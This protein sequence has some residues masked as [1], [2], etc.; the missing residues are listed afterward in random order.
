MSELLPTLQAA[1]LQEGLTKYLT[2]AFALADNDAQLSL[3]DF[4]ADPRDGIFKGPYVRIRLPFRPATDGWHNDLDWFEGFPPYGHQA[5]AFTR[6]S[7]A[8]LSD[9][10][11]RPLPTLVTTGT[12][13]GKTEAF[14]TPIIDHV[15]RAK[16]AGITGMKALILYPMNALAN[17][18]AKRLTEL[19]TTHD[20]LAGITAA[21]YTGQK[22]DKR[23]RVSAA[24]LITD[25][26]IMQDSAPDIVLTNYKMLDQLLLRNKDAPLWKQSAT[27]LQYIVLDEFHT[28]D[29]AQGTDV[30]M[31][32]RRLG[33][34]LKSYWTPATPGITPED[35][36]RPL[37]KITPIATSATLGDKGNPDVML[38]FAE[39]VF[40]EPFG[41][42]TVIT[43]TRL[44]LE[45][46][47]APGISFMA[48]RNL[49]PA[50]VDE[51]ELGTL[52]KAVEKLGQFAEARD[53]SR[54]VLRYLYPN[55]EDEAFDDNELLLAATQAH[56]FLRQLI[57]HTHE[58]AS[59]DDLAARVFTNTLGATETHEQRDTTRKL[60]LHNVIAML[61]HVRKVVGR[62]AASIDVHLW[63]RELSRIDR[64]ATA[65][66]QYQWS[67]DGVAIALPSGSGAEDA[68]RSYFP[69]VYCRHCGRSGWGVQLSPAGNNLDI[70]DTKI[71][72]NHLSREGRFRALMYAPREADPH[73]RDNTGSS[74]VEGL[75]WF[76]TKDRVLENSRPADDNPEFIDGYILPVLTQTGTEQEEESHNDDCPSCQQSDGIRFLGSAIATLLS[77]SLSNLFGSP[78]LDEGE[79][80]ALVFT[81]SVQDAAHRAGFIQSRSH[82]LSLRS[83]FHEA[84]GGRRINLEE[85]V[86]ETLQKAG[87]NK[88]RR[89]QLIA[90]DYADRDN[91]LDFWQAD[92]L[93]QTKAGTRTRVSHRLLFDALME[94][95]LSSRVGRT[96]E[97]TGSVVAEVDAGSS[98]KLVAI[99]R[100]I[101]DSIEAQPVIGYTPPTDAQ[102]A[103][104]VRG[105]LENL[106]HRG[107]IVHPWLVKYIRNDGARHWV[108]RGRPRADGMSA[109]PKGRQ[110]PA[111]ARIGGSHGVGGYTGE[112][113]N[114]A[115][116]QSWY[117][118]WA[119]KCLN[120]P[121]SDGAKFAKT[122]FGRLVDAGLLTVTNADSGAQIYG[123]SPQSILVSE[124]KLDDIRNGRHFL[125][126]SVCHS[127][128]PESIAV[129]DDLD[130]APCLYLRCPGT[131]VRQS[132]DDNYYR[133]L[134]SSS[135]MRRVVA[136][137][138]TGLLDDETRLRYENQ[139]KNSA[140][141][142]QAP[143][144]LVATP[145]LEMGIDIGDLSTV[146]LASLPR[147]VAS[148][149][150]RIGRAGRLTG[151]SLSLAFVRGRGEHLPKLGQPL[152]VINGEVRPPATYLNA[153]EILQ[154][155]FVAHLMDAFARDDTRQH[156]RKAT[157]AIGSALPDTFLG[158]IIAFAERD[159]TTHLATFLDAFTG[160]STAAV[161]SLTSWVTPFTDEGSSALAAHLYSASQRWAKTVSELEF[162]RVAIQASL[163]ELTAKALS[164][165]A[166]DD[167]KWAERS[168]KSNLRMIG[169]Q[170]ADLRGEFWIGVLEEYGILPNYT[171]LDDSVT[172]DFSLTWIDPDSGTFESSSHEYH[173]GSS[174]ALTELAPGATFYAEGLE[175]VVDAVDL[176]ANASAIRTL[177]FCP[178]CGF[179]RDLNQTGELIAVEV[180]PRCGSKAIADVKQ[181][182]EVV[183]LERVS[184]EV[185]RDEASINDSRDDRKRE[186]FST[187]VTADIDPEFVT[188][189]WF[190]DGYDFGVKYLRK[191]DVKWLNLGRATVANG[192]KRAIA[193]GEVP[194]PLFRVCGH[195][196]KLDSAA[197]T[198]RPEEH[199]AWCKY[200]K[201]EVESTRE[202]ALSHT[203]STQGA[204]I[205]LP[206]A[207]TIGDEFAGPSL[208]AAL[209]LGLRDQL[210]GSPDHIQI[211]TVIDPTT[212]EDGVNHEALLM[213]DTVPGGTGYLAEF[214]NP[215][216]VWDIIYRAWEVVKDCSCRN[217][218]RLACHKC[219]LPFAAPWQVDSV[220]RA[221]AERY[222]FQILSSG[223]S[224]ETNADSAPVFADWSISLVDTSVPNNESLL[225]QR[226]R[227]DLVARLKAVGA[228]VK[229]IPGPT[230]NRVVFTIPATHQTWTLNPQVQLPNCVPDFVLT[231]KV[232][233]VPKVAIFT[234]GWSFHA[235][236]EH[237]RTADDAAKR[238]TLR[239]AGYH[240]M[241]ITWEDLELGL[242]A[243]PLPGWFNAA[244]T[245]AV[246]AQ[247]A[248]TPRVLKLI[249]L[250]PMSQ[251]MEWVLNPEHEEW[252]RLADVI[253]WLMA[254]RS[255]MVTTDDDTSAAERAARHLITADVDTAPTGRSSW[256]YSEGFLSVVSRVVAPAAGMA[257][258]VELALVLDDRENALAKDDNAGWRAWLRLSNLTGMRTA[259]TAIHTVS[260]L[261]TGVFPLGSAAL[262]S[263]ALSE[264][265]ATHTGL[266]P[267]W[268]AAIALTNSVDERQLLI[269]LAEAGDF[270]LPEIGFETSDGIPVP[271]AWPQHKIVANVNLSS[272]DRDDLTAA[273]WNL[274]EPSAITIRSALAQAGNK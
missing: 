115:S 245:T 59:I 210:G 102:L 176:G 241:A 227:A 162:R 68:Y 168:A 189:Q 38:S 171:L 268:R 173:R 67:D 112:F 122:L 108:W 25:R 31:L 22:G 266:A 113:D 252:S 30:A 174:I 18:Q 196:G 258:G 61:S 138:H 201:A 257:S 49:T 161:D 231:S 239:L 144:V 95:G 57:E 140:D 141:D 261:E 118:R 75:R 62:E 272:L 223:K 128:N 149:T 216:Q 54:V 156:P 7:S 226:F 5:E 79:K 224:A 262:G 6:L 204:L 233:N 48:S 163:P 52:N 236:A 26:G 188:N 103:A 248:L 271:I 50:A 42:D 133:N 41:H 130:G 158:D 164:A 80:K 253:P 219:L 124:M 160:L 145:T 47:S 51:R 200:R 229:E 105:V 116:S 195:C 11:A 249:E 165:G 45:E 43:E 87:D 237:N 23:T 53:I 184:A 220:S 274:V 40:G 131:L 207:V 14:L 179:S 94:F 109:F 44:A 157:G 32:L 259:P 12:G 150:Q 110:A 86:A 82:A 37:G 175:V 28:Y 98:Q 143:N 170:L 255:T 136:R 101:L 169:K 217:E 60:F 199:R 247:F 35:R 106:R 9:T 76:H 4:L 139:F 58:A 270:E 137:E 135:R 243:F 70:D 215:R 19:L 83:V 153:E 172:L 246:M 127:L 265:A 3:D 114:A 197:K 27:S 97:M 8:N 192:S 119:G 214:A 104:W 146:I 205:R 212:D 2:T 183:E 16:K 186:I 228:T 180:C 260:Q 242:G 17:D 13:S 167:E 187:T 1:D 81:D 198:N 256:L 73:L 93:S 36:A 250:D 120:V 222:L 111:F 72:R 154:R 203:L 123:I 121:S 129:A 193:G 125:E 34:T 92:T 107:A 71:R 234:D 63:I 211:A 126:C 206:S 100:K 89:Y 238:E 99:A 190:V 269:S 209:L 39:T 159:A 225:E 221:T 232:I 240:V 142:P 91:F 84:V 64:A 155:Q 29:G 152:S 55:A 213:H 178:A 244:A 263:A 132:R 166:S 151:N 218:P 208:T 85:L 33:I 185:R 202:I 65:A 235:S 20:E 147:T 177:V 264:M 24:G 96:L 74:D 90:P 254:T 77:V 88:L 69:A 182:L 230:G 21:I 273:G 56:P 46:W 251:L 148:Y 194:T 191:V 117:S 66:V 10:K 181:R 78:T 134:Y 15:L 267:E